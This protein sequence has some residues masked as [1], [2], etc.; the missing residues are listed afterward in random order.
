MDHG[1]AVTHEEDPASGFKTVLGV[2]LFIV[3]GL[4]YA[5]FVL[6]NTF[7]PKLMEKKVF[8]G[9]NLAVTYG[10]GLILLAIVL[11]LVYNRIC[12]KKEDQM[13]AE[14]DVE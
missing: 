13:T 11:G 5:G 3:Y 7:V 10:F 8:F 12:T 14:G 6:L 4:I 2:R 9:L 1:P